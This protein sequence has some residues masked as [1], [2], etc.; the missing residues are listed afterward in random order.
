[1]K[2]KS[3]NKYDNQLPEIDVNPNTD[4]EKTIILPKIIY[5]GNKSFTNYDRRNLIQRLNFINPKDLLGLSYIR[6]VNDINSD[7]GKTIGC[8]YPKNKSRDAE[9]LLGQDLFGPLKKA[10]STLENLIYK[11]RLLETLYH[12]IG[13]HKVATTHSISKYKDEAYAEK[14][15]IAYKKAWF[16][17]NIPSKIGIIITDIFRS[18]IKTIAKPISYVLRNKSVV[19]KLLYQHLNGELNYEDFRTKVDLVFENK[20]RNKKKIHPL[21]KVGYR[22]K[23]RIKRR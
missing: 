19:A 23:F 7:Y 6:I 17:E 10:L 13:H 12:E 14:Y 1:M 22:N 2:K 3:F 4:F 16:K 5:E 9:I 18:I 11:D 20:Q 15:M 8:Y 21:N